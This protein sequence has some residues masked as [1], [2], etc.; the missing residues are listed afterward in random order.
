M[1]GGIIGGLFSGWILSLFGFDDVVTHGCKE[2]FNITISTYGY[3]LIF[4]LIG[5]ICGIFNID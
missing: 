4:A 3:Y 1:I 5:A 2:L